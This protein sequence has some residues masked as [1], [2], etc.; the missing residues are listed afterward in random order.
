[1]ALASARVRAVLDAGDKQAVKS[2]GLRYAHIALKQL[3]GK[4]DALVNISKESFDGSE[5]DDCDFVFGSVL[6]LGV[7]LLSS[8]CFSLLVALVLTVE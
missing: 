4:S 1:M 2:R 7:F 6:L 8:R 5:M 3:S